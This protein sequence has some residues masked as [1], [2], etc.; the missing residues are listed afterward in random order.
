MPVVAAS[1]DSLFAIQGGAF[2]SSADGTNWVRNA[3]EADGILP[4]SAYA[5]VC[6]PSTMYETYED[7][8]LTGTHEGD[9]VVWKRNLD[10]LNYNTYPW[11]YYTP[12]EE[13]TLTLPLMTSTTLVPYDDKVLDLVRRANWK[14]TSVPTAG[15]LGKTRQVDILFLS[16]PLRQIFPP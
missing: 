12:T 3:H 4:T 11:I 8:L 9:V 13:N 2:F 1:T 16:Y 7:L 5:A 6:T 10:R 15:G 14:L